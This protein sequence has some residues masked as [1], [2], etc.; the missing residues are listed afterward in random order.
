MIPDVYYV[1]FTGVSDVFGVC[2]MIGEFQ[3]PVPFANDVR[4]LPINVYHNIFCIQFLSPAAI[5]FQHFLTCTLLP[6]LVCRN[7]SF[8]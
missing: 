6:A 4:L 5:I 7:T 1:I 3:S 2:E 8:H